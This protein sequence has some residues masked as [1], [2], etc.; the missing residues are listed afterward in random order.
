MELMRY[1]CMLMEHA[2]TK[3]QINVD[4]KRS[5]QRLTDCLQCLVVDV[6]ITHRFPV[7]AFRRL[8]RFRL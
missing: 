1:V 3:K 6:Y 7:L 2:E 8:G 4:R 5:D